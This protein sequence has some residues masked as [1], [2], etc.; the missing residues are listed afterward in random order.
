MLGCDVVVCWRHSIVGLARAVTLLGDGFDFVSRI[1]MM[2]RW[3][4]SFF[5]LE[6][7]RPIPLC[8]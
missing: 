7:W 5:G 2:E 1:E 4:L 3:H 8:E 6:F